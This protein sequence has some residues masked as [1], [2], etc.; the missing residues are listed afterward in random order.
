MGLYADPQGELVKELGS[1]LDRLQRLIVEGDGESLGLRGELEAYARRRAR[2]RA[3]A[4]AAL[5][6]PEK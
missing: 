5:L 4:L 3:E 2:L 1:H 6:D